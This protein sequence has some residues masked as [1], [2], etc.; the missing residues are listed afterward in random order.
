MQLLCA[1]F[2]LYTDAEDKTYTGLHR[3]HTLVT[4]VCVCESK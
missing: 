1:N 3:T 4:V 2:W